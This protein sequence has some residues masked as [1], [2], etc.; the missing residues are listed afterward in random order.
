MI[1]NWLR[2]LLGSFMGLFMAFGTRLVLDS[3][4]F[5]GRISALRSDDTDARYSQGARNRK[6]AIPRLAQVGQPRTTEVNPE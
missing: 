1:K 3:R 6:G 4:V 5:A 2:S